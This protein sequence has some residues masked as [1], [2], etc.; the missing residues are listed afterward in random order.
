MRAC[1]PGCKPSDSRHREEQMQTSIFIARL[2]GPVMAVR[3]LAVLFNLRGFRD[4][5]QELVSSR[6]LIFLSGLIIM[7]AGIAIIL[8]HNIWAVDGRLMITLSG[9][10]LAIASAVRIVVLFFVLLWGFV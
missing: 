6:A 8:V 3:G 2:R 7:P 10:I 9:W 4:L 5:A 1:A